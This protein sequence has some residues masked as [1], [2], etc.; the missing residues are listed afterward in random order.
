V[1][2]VQTCALPILLFPKGDNRVLTLAPRNTTERFAVEARTSGAFPLTITVTS[3]DRDLLVT[4][5]QLTVRSTAVSGVGVFLA[6]GA[7]AFLFGWWGTHLRRRG[8]KPTRTL[9]TP[10]PVGGNDATGGGVD[11]GKA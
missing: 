7:G 5:S 8:V 1:T 2:G 3:P 11:A 10:E 4:S 9:A 6:G